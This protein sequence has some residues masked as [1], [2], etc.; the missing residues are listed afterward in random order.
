MYLT[1]VKASQTPP[2]S[3]S[4]NEIQFQGFGDISAS[5]TATLPDLHTSK[6]PDEGNEG[7]PSQ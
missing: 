2:L 5:S 3:D 6:E 4:D 1:M 7:E